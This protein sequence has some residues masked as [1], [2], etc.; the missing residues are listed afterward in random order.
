MK[1][2]LFSTLMVKAILE[3]RKTQTRRIIKPQPLVHNDVIKMPIPVDEYSKLLGEYTKKG[4][5]QIYTKG[6]LEG[7]I[8]PLCKYEVGDVLWVRETWTDPTPDQSGYPILYKAD[9]PMTYHGTEAD[10]TQTITLQAKD[11]KWKPSLFMPRDACRLFLKI[12]N[13]RVERLQ[14]ISE[15]DSVSEG[16]KKNDWEFEDGECPETYKE[17][18]KFLWESINGEK[19]WEDNPFVWVIEF[20]KHNEN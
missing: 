6:V 8:A 5:T 9:F 14:D 17:G 15:E 11:Y 3:G 10:P 12:K 19:S 2:I 13:I 4:Y 7:M 20:E 18:F 1:P 16:V